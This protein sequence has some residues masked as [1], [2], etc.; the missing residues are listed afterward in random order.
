MASLPHEQARPKPHRASLWGRLRSTP[1]ATTH[2]ASAPYSL[3]QRELLSYLAGRGGMASSF[4]AG[5]NHACSGSRCCCPARLNASSAAG[6]VSAPEHRR[7]HHVLCGC[8]LFDVLVTCPS[9][10]PACC[11]SRAHGTGREAH[12]FFGIPLAY[13]C[14]ADN[15]SVGGTGT[16]EHEGPKT[17][18]VWSMDGNS[19]AKEASRQLLGL[20]EMG[21]RDPAS[22]KRGERSSGGHGPRSE[23]VRSRAHYPMTGR[24]GA[25]GFAGMPSRNGE[26]GTG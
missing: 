5:A 18:R 3:A 13:T 14:G 15:R 8:G 22:H 19:S 17:D 21:G 1:S 10:I 25:I 7:P 20:G 2:G 11:W 23:F 16:E 24:N 12:F 4:V 9:P 26:L 6:G